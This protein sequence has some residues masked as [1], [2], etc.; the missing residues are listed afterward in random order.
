LQNKEYN[1]Q[2]VLFALQDYL[3]ASTR[4]TIDIGEFMSYVIHYMKVR[5]RD[6]FDINV[7]FGAMG[8]GNSAALGSKLAEPARPVVCITGDGCF[9][10]H[11]ME[12]ITAREYQLPILFVV[13]NNARLGMVYHGPAQQYQRSHLRFEQEPIDI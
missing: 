1:T 5:E 4:Y 12:L 9:F 11:G 8:S 2:N 3:P 6:T 7:H 13:I 10:M